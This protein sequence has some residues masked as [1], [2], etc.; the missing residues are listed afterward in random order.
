MEVSLLNRTV[1]DMVNGALPGGH[2][3][4]SKTVL[5]WSSPDRQ[6][7]IRLDNA[8]FTDAGGKA[9]A[10]V[11][12]LALQLS[13]PAL[14][15]GRI[16]PA[17]IELVGP[18]LTLTR[19]PGGLS[20][21][22]SLMDR[23]KEEAGEG[24]AAESHFVSSLIEALAREPDTSSSLGYLSRVA[25]RGATLRFNDAVNGVTLEAKSAVLVAYRSDRGV[26]ALYESDIVTDEGVSHLVLTGRMR[27]GAPGLNMQA[28]FWN[29]VPAAL[30]RLSPAFSDY[31][32]IDAP[33]DGTANLAVSRKGAVE[34]ATLAL[35]VRSGSIIA[36]LLQAAPI[37]VD[38]AHLELQ[39]DALK[40]VL[41]I[42][43]ARFQ[44]QGNKAALAGDISYVSG[45]G[46]NIDQAS[47]DLNATGITLLLPGVLAE[48]T[49]LDNVAFKG[50]VDFRTSEA[51]VGLL[52]VSR[53][54]MD[55]NLAGSGRFRGGG[56]FAKLTGSIDRISIRELLALWPLDVGKDPRTWVAE[57]MTS[58]FIPTSRLSVD[59]TPEM[60]ARAEAGKPLP[61]E[62]V[63][64][65]FNVEDATIIYVKEQPP[66]TG[67]SGHALLQADRF[68]GWVNRGVVTV[69]SGGVITAGNGYFRTDDF[70]LKD[71]PGVIN[72]D[73]AGATPDILELLDMKPFGY[74][75][76]F[77]LKP[78]VVGGQAAGHLMLSIPLS[79]H[80]RLDQVKISAQVKASGLTLPDVSPDINI[81]GGALDLDVT[82]D[83]L[84][85]KGEVSLNEVPLTLD[86]HQLFKARNGITSTYRISGTV[87]SAARK[88]LGLDTGD[89]LTGPVTIDATLSGNGDAIDTAHVSADLTE[90]QISVP[91]IGW[92][93]KPGE[94][95]HVTTD[96]L[97]PG[98]K[99]DGPFRITN[100]M[101][102]GDGVAAQGFVNL[103]K[104]GA[105]LQADLRG[106]KLGPRNDFDLTV[107][108]TPEGVTAIHLDGRSFDAEPLLTRLGKN[109]N[110]DKHDQT[111]TPVD[112]NARLD[113]VYGVDEAIL[114]DVRIAMSLRDDKVHLL[115][116]TGADQRGGHFMAVL[117]QQEDDTRKLEARADDAG[118]LAR[119]MGLYDN[120][121][122]GEL[123]ASGTIDDRMQGSPMS[124]L[125][126]VKNFRIVKAPVLANI[127]T[128]GSFTG[129]RDTLAGDGVF[130]EELTLPYR[131]TDM[132]YY[133]D[134]GRAVGPA[135]GI[136]V[137]GSVERQGSVM[138]L[139]GTITPAYF[140]N[141][142]IG[143][144]PLIGP[145][146][147]GREGEG[148][149][150]F[151][152][153]VRGPVSD[154]G[155][156]V[157]P[158]SAFAPGFLRRIFEYSTSLANKS[159][160]P[161]LPPVAGNAMLPP[162][163]QPDE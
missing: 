87:K 61:N 5:D 150:A 28:R 13:I 15:K 114:T 104:T 160:D 63:R 122:G 44:A 69:P 136:S 40:H 140:L 60:I 129:I 96:I 49:I 79:K 125:V 55:I 39:L 47:F 116:L 90:A 80:V 8:V 66:I 25:I 147:V 16:A 152:Y 110:E 35:D 58:G 130:F 108:T 163:R 17:D 131:M 134:S 77:G 143:R 156:S 161:D 33:V 26:A 10:T 19:L 142:F 36:P 38:K 78:R 30:A 72:T 9:I 21:G 158:L 18:S 151:T 65:T 41:T 50:A 43:S 71:A 48:Q 92:R 75:S 132:R 31:G 74:I 27:Q 159:P 120:I 83:E 73:I 127:L 12:Q 54:D 70:A 154:P 2:L 118:A 162:P 124:G 97:F 46:L 93:K 57:S 148:L 126:T 56:R 157:N 146:I 67:A 59:L 29:V 153:A 144:I 62:A 117:S 149:F 32:S 102:D 109:S 133:L 51:E 111:S 112:I 141:S 101:L 82:Q 103:S 1:E 99:S 68:E 155:V 138:D 89:A 64:L 123:E 106:V 91:P 113:E 137:S 37:A 6:L 42:R 94:K 34:G 23:S 22:L 76:S 11:P 128:L 52:H 85:A 100:L 20:F 145:W 53:G 139:E 119:A 4:I 86:W 24:K 107:D 115:D 7:V 135:M 95:A 84:K 88:A 3:S 45:K 121:R 105:L 81:T 14:L 98:E